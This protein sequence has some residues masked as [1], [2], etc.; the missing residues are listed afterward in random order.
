VERPTMTRPH[1]D[2]PAKRSQSKLPS[3]PILPLSAFSPAAATA[4]INSR[5]FSQFSATYISFPD[6]WQSGLD[7]G[8]VGE[9]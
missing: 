8:S 3:I 6:P 2:E 7:V 9:G 5:N 4:H 1:E